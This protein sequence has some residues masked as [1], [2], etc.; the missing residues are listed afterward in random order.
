[1][2]ATE[3]G[4][5]LLAG[6]IVTFAVAVAPPALAEDPELAWRDSWGHVRPV[7]F[8]VMAASAGVGATTNFAPVAELDWGRNPLDEAMRDALRLKSPTARAVVGAV[9]EA[10]F[11]GVMA[12]PIVVDGLLA[13]LPRS[14]E[15]AAQ[16][17]A[18]DFESLAVG[19]MTSMVLEHLAGRERPFVRECRANTPGTP[20]DCSGSKQE[21]HQSFPSGHTIMAFTGAGLMCAH[22]AN[23]PLYGGGAPDALACAF[24]LAGATFN[25]LARVMTDRHYF[26]DILAGAAI[27]L[28]AGLALPYALHYAH[29]DDEEAVRASAPIAPHAPAPK[30]GFS[31]RF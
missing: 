15:V 11:Y 4:R 29:G 2:A 5:G 1:M 18:I 9:G 28:G 17:I 13:A 16:T 22:H 26:T 7:E 10:F 21:E 6:W 3:P 20:R 19:A 31:G 30:L 12:Y 25:G 23:L 27:G 14:P 24:G 8:F